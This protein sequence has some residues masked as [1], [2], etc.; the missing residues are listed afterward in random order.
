MRSPFTGPNPVS[1]VQ[2]QAPGCFDGFGSGHWVTQNGAV[3]AGVAFEAGSLGEAA[4]GSLVSM[5]DI[6]F[7]MNVYDLPNWQN[8]TKNLIR[9]LGEETDPPSQVP[10][11]GSLVLV[12]IAVLAAAGVRRRRTA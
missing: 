9:F 10:E 8:L 5:L 12:G 1:L 4:A 7:M 11:P 3:G 6:N 2:F